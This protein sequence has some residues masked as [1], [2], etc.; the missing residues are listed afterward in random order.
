MIE[1]QSAKLKELGLRIT[2][3]RLAILA[4]LDGDTSHPSAM[5][6]HRRLAEGY[7]TLSLATVYNTLEALAE[8]GMLLELPITKGKLNYDPDTSDHD[9]AYCSVCGRIFD[10][11]PEGE[12]R[13]ASLPAG[14]LEGA[15]LLSV[16]RVYYIACK[17]CRGKE[18]L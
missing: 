4:A 2:P 16:R 13:G 17:E 18:D 8:N 7:P 15:R 12:P 14:A 6:I 11:F 9:H 5:E 3:Q 10:V 1:Q